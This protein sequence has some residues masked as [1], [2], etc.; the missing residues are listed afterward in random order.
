MILTGEANVY[1]QDA[2]AITEMNRL[3]S[4]YLALFT[5]KT[6]KETRAYVYDLIPTKIMTAA[7]VVLFKFSKIT[8]P[9]DLSKGGDPVNIE[10]IPALKTKDLVV[11]SKSESVADPVKKFD[12]LYYRVP[13]IVNIRISN[14]KEVLYNSR[15][16]IYQFGEVITLPANFI[17][18]K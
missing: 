4:E 8:G 1:P 11:I 12:K 18:G 13:D 16:L 5:G 9:G 6:W 15:K 2:S 17:I 14:N 3:E 7:P 10:F